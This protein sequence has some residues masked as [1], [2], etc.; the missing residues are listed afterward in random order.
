MQ[1]RLANE[2]DADALVKHLELMAPALNIAEKELVL[3]PEREREIIRSLGKNSF[4]MIAEVNS[5]I[6]GLITVQAY[7]RLSISHNAKVGLSVNPNYQAQGVGRALLR[8]AIKHARE[9]TELY[10]LEILSYETNRR[11]RSFYMDEGFG[12]EGY[13]E[14]YVRTDNGYTGAFLLAYKLHQLPRDSRAEASLP[15][16]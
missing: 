11:A 6:A 1:V 7:S 5:E 3:T 10:R 9:H 14:G 15:T 4:F 12:F 2:E 8:A 16:Y 13:R